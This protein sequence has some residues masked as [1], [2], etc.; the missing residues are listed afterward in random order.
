M[1]PLLP[2]PCPVWPRRPSA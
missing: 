2:N 1:F